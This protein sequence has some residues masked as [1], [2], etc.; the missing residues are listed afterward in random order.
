MNKQLRQTRIL[1]LVQR[2]KIH[3]Q[4]E[5]AK[6]L[7]GQGIRATQVT[8]S[9]DIK[10]LGLAKT[11]EG[12]AAVHPQAAV[13]EPKFA[14]LAAEVLRDIRVAQNLIVLKTSPGSASGLAAALDREDWP[15]IVG[16]IAGDDT[17][18]V[19]APDAQTAG[20][21]KAKLA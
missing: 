21:L 14:S 19:I 18:L 16:T 10:E 4:E 9:R 8:L 17:L 3:T 5:L 11:A 15:E 13:Q 2:K 12:Y 20:K 1:Q 6:A 7:A